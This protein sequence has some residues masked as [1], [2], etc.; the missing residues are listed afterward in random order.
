MLF[1]DAQHESEKE[2]FG[3]ALL[4]GFQI[5]NGIHD[6]MKPSGDVGQQIQQRIIG[7]EVFV[8]MN[9]NLG[10][11]P[12]IVDECTHDIV[13]DGLGEFGG[14]EAVAEDDGVDA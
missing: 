12:V 6:R 1:Q 7:R 11:R 9:H 2:R 8:R 5:F 10:V 14:Q 4:H 13:S 3:K